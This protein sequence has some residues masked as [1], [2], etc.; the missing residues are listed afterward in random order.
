[1]QTLTAPG[2]SAMIGAEKE[3]GE[4]HPDESQISGH[5]QLSARPCH[6]PP[7]FWPSCLAWSPTSAPLAALLGADE[8]RV[9][10][11]IVFGALLFLLAA[12]AIN[13]ALLRRNARSGVRITAHPVNLLLAAVTLGLILAFAGAIVVDQYPC[14]IGVPNC[15]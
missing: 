4:N 10:S 12:F 13:F 15:D 6:S 3:R 7:S 1:M 14:W 8:G 11:F 2:R 9:G 5:Y